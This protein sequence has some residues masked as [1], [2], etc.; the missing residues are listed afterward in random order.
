MLNKKIIKK[1]IN[2]TSLM[3]VLILAH[4]QTEGELKHPTTLVFPHKYKFRIFYSIQSIL[5]V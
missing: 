1:R 2:W 5:F 4:L 3:P